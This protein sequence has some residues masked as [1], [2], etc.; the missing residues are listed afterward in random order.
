MWLMPEGRV[1]HVSLFETWVLA[2]KPRIG[3]PSLDSDPL[4][5]VSGFTAGV[6][7]RDD[8]N[9]P[10]RPLPVN[11]DERKLPQASLIAA[12]EEHS[13]HEFL[14]LGQPEKEAVERDLRLF[15]ILSSRPLVAGSAAAPGK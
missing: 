7:D 8:L 13:R 6:S 5:P 9:I 11:Q 2:A 4:F 3:G 14:R 15:V 10:A 12:P 1:P